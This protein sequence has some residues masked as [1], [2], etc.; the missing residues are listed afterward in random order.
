[1]GPE[2]TPN[3]FERQ[4]PG[5][6]VNIFSWKSGLYP[7]HVSKEAG[8]EID[9]LL[10]T[11]TKEPQKTLCLDQGPGPIVAQKQ[12]VQ[13]AKAPMPPLST[14]LLKQGLTGKPQK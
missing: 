1:L 3:L 5:L 7:L 12:Q 4:N 8:R 13:R 14:R 9:L 6:S 11:D 10:L 2:H